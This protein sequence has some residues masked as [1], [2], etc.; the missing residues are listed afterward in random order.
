MKKHPAIEQLIE[1]MKTP[2]WST[3]CPERN[4]MELLNNWEKRWLVDVT[5]SQSVVSTKYL[6]SEYDDII[7][8]QL[9]QKLA[10]DLAEDC[11]IFSKES[12][13]ISAKMC[14]FRRKEKTRE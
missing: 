6:T 8:L 3:F 1:I 13:N 12:K 9:T 2:D 7:K 14:A 5:Y 10:E 4:R 11:T